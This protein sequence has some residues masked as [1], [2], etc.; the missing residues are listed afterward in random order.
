MSAAVVLVRSP[1]DASASIIEASMNFSDWAASS[2]WP[3][4]FSK[5]PETG[6][7]ALIIWLAVNS[8]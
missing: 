1:P 4:M 6:A 7:K 3:Y 2:A 8:V 5:A